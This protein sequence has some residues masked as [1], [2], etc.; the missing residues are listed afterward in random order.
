M[1][2]G[3]YKKFAADKFFYFT[4]FF[5]LILVFG[6][7]FYFYLTHS[8]II[9]DE[10]NL[11]LNLIDKNFLDFFKPL[12]RLQVAPPMFM[13]LSKIVYS[14]ITF[15]K[16]AY[17]SDILLRTVPFVSGTVAIP[18]FG[19][20]LYKI[21]GNKLTV[22]WGMFLLGINPL[23]IEYSCSFKQYSTEMLVLIIVFILSF[24]INFK[25]QTFKQNLIFALLIAFSPLFSM[26][27]IFIL[28]CAFLLI[29][30]R[31]FE[32]IK[33]KEFLICSGSVVFII[34]LYCLLYLM[35]IFDAHYTNMVNYWSIK[36]SY[37]PTYYSFYTN[38]FKLVLGISQS[39]LYLHM[40]LFSLCTVSYLIMIKRNYKILL[41]S[42]LPLFITFLLIKYN[43]YALTARL[44]L[45]LLPCL[46]IAFLFLIDLF[47]KINKNIYEFQI[48]I[49]I[50]A[51]VI[52]ICD[53]PDESKIFSKL[54]PAKQIIEYYVG[55]S[56]DK[57][58]LIAS[59][60]INS[61]SYYARFFN[62][63]QR[64]ILYKNYDTLPKGVYNVLV[65]RINKHST[66]FI[67]KCAENGKIIFK[68]QYRIYNKKNKKNYAIYFVHI[69]EK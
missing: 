57:K 17:F 50:A 53:L 56:D 25:I 18:A 20:L 45:F 68:K 42:F 36:K 65:T 24:E 39:C 48:I 28:P 38:Y 59:N 10:A 34:C 64:L 30:L 29:L 52:L 33:R 23:A 41:I 43:Y 31:N 16:T 9:C 21:F 13:V 1:L 55:N 69:K 26:T 49:L 60:S 22:L 27:A 4:V 51:N 11:A 46:L 8:S 62:L 7:R 61:I 66:L 32:Y 15:H 12:D 37:V 6:I 19:Y 58:P 35:N 40:I 67:N 3:L 63:K 2:K 14:L 47:N 5:I 44:L 54:E